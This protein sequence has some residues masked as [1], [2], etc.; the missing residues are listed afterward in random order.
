MQSASNIL[1]S[2]R[3][4]HDYVD[5]ETVE[6][7]TNSRFSAP[8]FSQNHNSR[9]FERCLGDFFRAFS[10]L[11][12]S[13]RRD[14]SLDITRRKSDASSGFGTDSQ[15]FR[16]LEKNPPLNYRKDLVFY[17]SR[18]YPQNYSANSRRISK[19]RLSRKNLDD[20]K[21]KFLADFLRI[22]DSNFPDPSKQKN[23]SHLKNV[24]EDENQTRNGNEQPTIRPIK[25]KSRRTKKKK[26]QSGNPI[27]SKNIEALHS[28]AADIR[29]KS[30]QISRDPIE[31]SDI[32]LSPPVEFRNPIQPINIEALHSAAADIGF[33]SIQISRDPI[34]TSDIDLSPPVE[35]RNPIQPINI[36]ALHSA[37]ADIGFKSIHISRDPIET[38]DIDL[39]PP[40]EFRNPIKPNN[41]EAT[42]S[43]AADIGFKSNPISRGPKETLETDLLPPIQFRNPIKS[44]NIGA[45]DE[46][47][48]DTRG[49]SIPLIREPMELPETDLLNP[50]EVREK[51]KSV[52]ALLTCSHFQISK[53]IKNIHIYNENSKTTLPEFVS[54][55]FFEKLNFLS[56]NLN[57]L[58]DHPRYFMKYKHIPN[59][60]LINEIFQILLDFISIIRDI[61]LKILNRKRKPEIWNR[62]KPQNEWL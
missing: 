19:D 53:L 33:K 1:A 47:A 30:I 39:F 55:N 61:F 15:G 18:N 49:K 21:V 6:R 5:D 24:S 25:R 46:A 44:S 8:V 48:I 17:N 23:L 11:L 29:F 37:A 50:L 34:E 52:I 42:H 4:H 36:E 27:K 40:I 7:N 10:G 45:I 41:I 14:S 56:I 43:A 59:S 28:A 22:M 62:F 54:L 20:E 31:T 35:F 12:G 9:D 26:T 3:N 32:D 58:N 2:S 51:C 38:S 57:L 60:R 13:R 16:R